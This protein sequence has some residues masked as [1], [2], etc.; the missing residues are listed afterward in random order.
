MINFE[1]RRMR[2]GDVAYGWPIYSEAMA[3]LVTG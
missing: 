3:P 1:F 2:T